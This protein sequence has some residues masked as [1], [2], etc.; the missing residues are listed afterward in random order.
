M[1]SI[2]IPDSEEF[3]RGCEE[4]VK[5]EKCDAMYNLP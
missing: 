1:V 5:H 3:R 2:N 4:Y